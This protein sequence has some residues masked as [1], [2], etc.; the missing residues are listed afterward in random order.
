MRTIPFLLCHCMAFFTL[1]T[2][3]QKTVHPDARYAE[4]VYIHRKADGFKGIWYMNQPSNDE[5]VYKYSGGMATYPANHRPF[6]IYSDKV[7]KTFFC[8][9][10]TDEQNST[11]F[12]N[13]SYF[14]HRS[15]M[16]ANPT[17]VLDKQTTDAHDN[18]V[19]SIDGKGYIWIFSTSH[20]T[21]RPSYISRSVKRY[22]I[23]RFEQV[24]ATEVVNGER[25]PFSN[26]S[27]FQVYYVKKKGFIALFT[28]YNKSG[29][30]VIGFNTSKD[31]KS[32]NE[33][34]VIAHIE[35]GHYQIS[36]ER[37]GKIGVAF[38]YHPKG[39][40]LNYRTN[41]Y[42]LE[43][44]DFGKTWTT[45][46]GSEVVLPL[47]TIE[48]P[49]LVHDYSVPHWNSYLL[50]IN[51]DEKGHPVI[52]TVTSKGYEAG[53]EKGPRQWTFS[54]HENGQWKAYPVTVSDSNYDMGS[55]YPLGGK[56]F[57]II[58]PTVDGPQAFNPG[59]EIAM[60]QSEDG[61]QR[62]KLV[63]QLTHHS[64]MNHTYVRRPRQASPAFYAIWADG[65]GRKPSISYLY[66]SDEQ[67]N[68]FRMPREG[69]GSLLLPERLTDSTFSQAVSQP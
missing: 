1:A 4:A 50:D 41:L 36:A 21:S 42:Y 31:G 15:G 11:L 14:D 47:T 25:V 7:K 37:D 27:Y 68:V 63:K 65:H 59:G 23:E 2:A 67:G 46:A 10:G 58:G 49:A 20:G 9:G 38:D 16:L 66:F 13:V 52:L 44:A 28:K 3:Q 48:N 12:H 45:A 60:W 24:P 40:G 61:G 34:Q 54:K 17:V 30:R 57:Q 32:W 19:I 39:K 69:S 35:D 62:W 26:F 8:F 64:S 43:T 51:F 18:P 53:P 22:D 33:W 55:I 56:R 29:H 5:Y 6:A